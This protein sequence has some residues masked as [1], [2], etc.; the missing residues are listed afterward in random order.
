[1]FEVANNSAPAKFQATIRA[2]QNLWKEDLIVEV[3]SISKEGKGILAK[4]EILALDY[5][6][7][8]PDPKEGWKFSD[9]THDEVWDVLKFSSGMPPIDSELPHGC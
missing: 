4:M 6:T 1:L 8:K 9:C 2:N 3:Y 7:R 5:F